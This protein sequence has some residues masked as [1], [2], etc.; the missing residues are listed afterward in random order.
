[1]SG[2]S[3]E[4]TDSCIS[5]IGYILYLHYHPRDVSEKEDNVKCVD[6]ENCNNMK[7]EKEDAIQ[8]IEYDCETSI[9]TNTIN[10]AEVVI[11]RI[12]L[13]ELS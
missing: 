10:G 6:S 4:Y 1:M 7:C 11:D 8:K 2:S 5:A 13:Q 12:S 9:M 3:T